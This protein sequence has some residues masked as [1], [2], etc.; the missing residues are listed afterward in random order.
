MAYGPQFTLS[1]DDSGCVCHI[2][3]VSVDCQSKP[4]REFE[5]HLVHS[6]VQRSARRNH[7]SSGADKPGPNWTP[8]WG[9]PGPTSGGGGPCIFNAA[10]QGRNRPC[11]KQEVIT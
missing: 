3:S 5:S 2:G 11:R 6:V 7:G 1:P 4:A 9:R 8:F 10:S